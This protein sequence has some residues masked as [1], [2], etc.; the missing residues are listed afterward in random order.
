VPTVE[1]PPATPFTV[2]V[3]AVFAAFFTVAVNCLVVVTG[4]PALE[5]ATVTV[6]PGAAVTLKFTGS[7]LV[8]PRPVLVTTM[9]TLVPTWAAVAVPLAFRPVDETKVVV[10]G[11]PP[12]DTTELAPKFAPLSDMVKG[13]T[14]TEVG[15]VLQRYTGGWVMMMVTVPNLVASAVLVACTVT[16][17]MA[18]TTAGAWYKPLGDTLPYVEFPP[19]TPF[20][21]QVTVLTANGTYAVS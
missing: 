16:A 12:K 2:Q 13:P 4:T 15:D 18:G 17:F 5:G 14:G 7:L 21:D 19:R 20:T 1:F 11:V 3:T 8:P 10:I 6:T 9:G